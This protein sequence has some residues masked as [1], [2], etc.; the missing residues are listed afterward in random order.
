MTPATGAAALPARLSR[1]TLA[2]LTA[3]LTATALLALPASA[4]G[5]PATATGITVTVAYDPQT[6]GYQLAPGVIERSAGETFTLANTMSSANDRQT[7]YVSITNGSGKVSMGGSACERISSCKVLDNYSASA[8]G[9]VTVI[10]PG[11]FTITRVLRPYVG[12]DDPPITVGTLTIR[13]ED[14][15]EQ[16]IRITDSGRTVV[17]GKP[18]IYIEGRALGFSRTARVKVWFKFPGETEYTQSGAQPPLDLDGSFSWS[19]KTGKKVYAYVTSIN[20]EI[21]SGRVIIPAN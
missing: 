8:T 2:V 4:M 19:R 14:P 13:G 9:T 17:I 18:G 15:V 3:A 5:S 21:T 11:T 6:M 1:T 16:T 20:G 7:V 12:S 10:E